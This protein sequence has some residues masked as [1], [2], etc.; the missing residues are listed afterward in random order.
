MV[1]DDLRPTTLDG[2]KSLAAQLSKERGMQH[3][4]ALD[5]A[6]RA[7]DCENFK[8]ARRTLPARG[9]GL[10]HP[11]VLLTIYWT[12]KD[13]RW[14]AGRETLRIELAR[15]ILNTCSRTLLKQVRGFGNLRM[16]APDHFVCD[17]IAAN[18]DYARERLTTAERSLRFME[19]TGL[20]PTRDFRRAYPNGQAD[21]KL[22]G[23]DHST[24]WVDPATG[25]FILV[26][27]PYR[28]A[29]DTA[30][31]ADWMAR[32]GWRVTATSWP[33]MYY[34]HSCELHVATDVRTGYNLDALVAKIEAMPAPLLAKD[35]AG[36]SAAGWETFVSPMAKTP[37]DHRR[38]RCRGTIYPSV[39][40]TSVPY[41]YNM[42]CDRR[43]PNGTMP[44]EGHIDVGSII[45]AVLRTRHRPY[46]VYRRLNSL[47]STLED[48]F[49]LEIGRGQIEGP[50]FFDV[51]Y[52]EGESENPYGERASS[53]DG[54]LGLLAELK[55]KLQAAYPDSAPLRAELHLVTMSIRLVERM[56]PN[57]N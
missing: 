53:K 4:K 50:E 44:V 11:Y 10:Q 1:I 3:L 46:G 26:D 8:H 43:R 56:K 57:A 34:P 30:E 36:V 22:P 33:G 16:A 42:G 41:S 32:T 29:P 5:L 45:K 47:R 51:Y 31:R 49:S 37:Q 55:A 20:M 2:V 21:D 54:V 23:N 14:Q 13:K 48:W 15:P 12:D 27:E 24:D 17:T 18:Q 52:H 7:A 28:R 38:A 35:W 9:T 40:K 25:Q 19:R 39:T 6:A